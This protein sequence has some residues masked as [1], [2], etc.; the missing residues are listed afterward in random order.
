MELISVKINS[1]GTFQVLTTNKW[2]HI[3]LTRSGSTFTIWV[4]GINRASGNISRD[5]TSKSYN[6]ALP[7]FQRLIP[8]DVYIQDLRLYKGVVKYTSNFN[9]SN[10][11]SIMEP[12]TP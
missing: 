7:N 6:F 2:H 4:D 8:D 5:L 3:A 11:T 9:T 12:Y 1:A 10:V